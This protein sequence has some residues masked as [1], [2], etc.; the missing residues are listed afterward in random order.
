MAPRYILPVTLLTGLITLAIGIQLRKGTAPIATFYALCS[1]LFGVLNLA[2]GAMLAIGI[3]LT[4]LREYGNKFF[5]EAFYSEQPVARNLA[6]ILG[7]A[8]V[9][10][11]IGLLWGSLLAWR[12]RREYQRWRETR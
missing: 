2:A 11:G 1:L 8:E 6:F 5:A 7:A 3:L 12:G 9:I 10:L 4:P